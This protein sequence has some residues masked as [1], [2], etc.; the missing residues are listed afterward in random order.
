MQHDIGGQDGSMIQIILMQKSNH[1]DYLE[2][3]LGY[4]WRS[5]FKALLQQLIQGIPNPIVIQYVEDV[6]VLKES[7]EL[8][9]SILLEAH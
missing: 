8:V 1:F 7:V 3:D 4:L 2:D 9:Q 6:P 5:Q